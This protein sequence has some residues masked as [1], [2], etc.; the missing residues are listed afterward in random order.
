MPDCIGKCKQQK[1]GTYKCR[2]QGSKY[3]FRKKK[4]MVKKIKY[5]H[6]Y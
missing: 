2:T 3:S 5:S 1:N 6:C 4:L